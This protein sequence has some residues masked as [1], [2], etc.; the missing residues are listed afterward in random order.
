MAQ[1]SA[2]EELMPSYVDHVRCAF[3]ACLPP[4]TSPLTAALLFGGY[5]EEKGT[6]KTSEDVERVEATFRSHVFGRPP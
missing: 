1:Q 3:I 5:T 2:A 4:P 6:Q